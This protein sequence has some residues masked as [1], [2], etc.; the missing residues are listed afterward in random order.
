MNLSY[1]C[2]RKKH[3]RCCDCKF[4]FFLFCSSPPVAEPTS[5]RGVIFILY[6]CVSCTTFCARRF[7]FIPKPYDIHATNDC[8][9]SKNRR[10]K[11]VWSR[12]RDRP[13][14]LLKVERIVDIR[15]KPSPRPERSVRAGQSGF[16]C[17]RSCNIHLLFGPRE[18]RPV[19]GGRETRRVCPGVCAG[20]TSGRRER[21]YAC[22]FTVPARVEKPNIIITRIKS[23]TVEKSRKP[24]VS[25]RFSRGI[26]GERKKKKRNPR[27]RRFHLFGIDC[28][29]CELRSVH[30]T[31]LFLPT[32]PST[33]RFLWIL[34]ELRRFVV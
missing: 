25:K 8:F 4:V 5:R 9:E 2:A 14:R 32:E 22:G 1:T 16:R 10:Y 26:F 31:T 28:V 29:V 3:R 34:Y 6:A 27:R 30:E 20:G 12:P 21:S 19:A 33:S 24:S 18:I 11:N 17:V 23:A 7:C 13:S 15:G